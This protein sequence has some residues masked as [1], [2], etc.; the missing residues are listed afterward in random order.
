MLV[1]W[2]L[3][4]PRIDLKKRPIKAYIGSQPGLLSLKGLL[5]HSAQLYNIVVG[6]PNQEVMT[7]LYAKTFDPNKLQITH[8]TVEK[9][10]FLGFKKNRYN[11]I[12][13]LQSPKSWI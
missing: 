13:K 6:G 11:K 2:P 12:N 7:C 9:V 8:E 1:F 4:Y 3:E 10:Q 5:D